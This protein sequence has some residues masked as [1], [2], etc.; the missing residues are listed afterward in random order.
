MKMK[1]SLIFFCAAAMSFNLT[2]Y[3][4]TDTPA[5]TAGTETKT[6]QEGDPSQEPTDPDESAPVM[7]NPGLEDVIASI[8][9]SPQ[10]IINI[11][12]E[13]GQEFTFD[14]PSVDVTFTEEWQDAE[15]S[16]FSVRD[17]EFTDR[18]YSVHEEEKTISIQPPT[19]TAHYTFSIGSIT[20]QKD[21]QAFTFWL[22]DSGDDTFW[23]YNFKAAE[24]PEPETPSD[25]GSDD[26]NRESDHDN[27]ESDES[28]GYAE[29]EPVYEKQNN[30]VNA[31]GASVISTV[32][33]IY[34][35]SPIKGLAITTAYDTVCAAAGIQENAA[36]G[37]KLS[38]YVCNNS[39]PLEQGAF[40]EASGLL[41]Q[42]VVSLVDVDMY[43]FSANSCRTVKTLQAPIEII[44]GLPNW[45]VQQNAV[46][47]V[48]CADEEGRVFL[49]PD[50]DSNAGT[51]TIQTTHLGTC[52]IV[53]PLN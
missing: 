17:G 36:A 8:S 21:G 42:K 51:I 1:K 34:S 14:F 22:S 47:S 19:R 35:D 38:L 52:A 31:G 6:V 18:N 20:I 16:G 50:M 3:A 4:E 43:H 30:Q 32:D 24:T 49:L 11:S 40:T 5:E 45:A 33:G 46:F 12:G 28:D 29:E 2:A 15:V 23:A 37:E 7:D 25:P 53:S 26:Q 13:I 48:L 10:G 27:R 41:G 44:I 39:N 9:I